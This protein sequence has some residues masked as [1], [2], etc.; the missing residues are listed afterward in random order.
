MSD[1]EP[2]IGIDFGSS[3]SSIAQFSIKDKKSIVFQD[4]IGEKLISSTVFFETS[5]QILTG[6]EANYCNAKENQ[7]KIQNIKRYIGRKYEEIDKEDDLFE[8]LKKEK[9]NNYKMK[10][11]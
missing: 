5:E 6:N 2:I 4:T 8:L 11:K 7:Y 3:F 10:I 9:D 1:N